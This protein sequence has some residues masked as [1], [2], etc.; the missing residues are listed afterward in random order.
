[1]TPVKESMARTTKIAFAGQHVIAQFFVASLSNKWV[2]KV[3]VKEPLLEHLQN[4]G[5]LA[6]VSDA[7]GSGSVPSCAMP[8][9]A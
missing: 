4:V 9:P 1:M 3:E 7:R 5:E 8:A 6:R 2:A